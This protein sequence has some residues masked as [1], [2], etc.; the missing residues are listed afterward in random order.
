MAKGFGTPYYIKCLN[1]MKSKSKLFED[2][3]KSFGETLKSIKL[4]EEKKMLSSYEEES[5]RLLKH[6]YENDIYDI[7]RK[8]RL[9]QQNKPKKMVQNLTA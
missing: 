2:L 5:L 9:Y 7:V 4:L 8:F 1:D 6:S 3:M